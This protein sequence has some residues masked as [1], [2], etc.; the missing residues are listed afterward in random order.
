MEV[1][2]ARIPE[3]VQEAL[4]LRL[5]VFCDEQGVALSAEQD[6]RDHEAIHVVAVEGGRVVG[7]C[8][9]LVEHGVARLGRNAVGA[10]DRG[11]GIGTA[12]LRAADGVA[13]R[14]GADRVR[15]HAQLPARRL[16]ERAGYVAEGEVFLEEGI[17]HVTMEKR[18]A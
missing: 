11:R 12:L 2:E 5:R 16:Y 17:E 15:L 7:T 1:R 8:R 4:E 6:G 10:A 18:L 3:E 14:S 13:A 9:L